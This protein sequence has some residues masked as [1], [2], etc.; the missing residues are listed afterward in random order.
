MPPPLVLA[1]TS[2]YRRALVERLGL[3]FACL[4]PP[5]DEEAL[6][7]AGGTPEDLA[8][9]LA[10]AKARAAAARHPQAVVI[11]GDQICA[12]GD[13]IL[14]KPRSAERA[15]EQLLR[16]QGREHRLVT[17]LAVVHPGGELAHTDITRLAM[18][19]LDRAALE[20]YVAADQPLD[21]A[22]AY[23]LEQRGIT[24][25]ERIDSQDHDA[26]VGVP[27]LWLT[28]ILAGLGYQMP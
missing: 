7:A 26:I 12:L 19:R 1:S 25:F 17:A 15:V 10:L 23:K 28:G 4:A 18:R 8:A 16:L 9:R 6:K 27:M 20:R 11:G 21:C 14:H 2:P 22:G 24:L 3:P 5:C 13:D